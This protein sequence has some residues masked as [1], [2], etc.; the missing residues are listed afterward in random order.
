MMKNYQDSDYA[1]NKYANGIV[2][3][4][5]NQTVR[6]TL[7]DYLRENPGKTEADFNEI[8]ALSD[9]LFYEQDRSEGRQRKKMV[10]F[11]ALEE[12]ELAAVPSPEDTMIA[13]QEEEEK[14]RR[15]REIADRAL[16]VLTEVQR[17]RYLLH[18]SQGLTTREIAL[19]EGISHVAV[20]YSLELAE[21]KIKKV[22]ADG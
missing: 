4:F 11:H 14:Q 22:L 6:V 18:N 15:R 9:R 19:Q 16:A 20:V 10:S 7:D 2:Y 21:K 5:A 3:R 12:T 17:R 8:K 13:E 1:A